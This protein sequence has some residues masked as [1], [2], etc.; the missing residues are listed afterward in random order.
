MSS[1][2]A[3]V[4][5]FPQNQSQITTEL[6]IENHSNK[7][8]QVIFEENLSQITYRYCNHNREEEG[9][10]Q[11]TCNVKRI[12]IS[13]SANGIQFAYFNTRRDIM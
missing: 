7:I 11:L 2:T 3:L 9:N 13:D 10:I 8:V 6:Q 5:L 12:A 1:V 4:N